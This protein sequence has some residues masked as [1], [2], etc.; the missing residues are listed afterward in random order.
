MKVIDKQES[1]PSVFGG[2]KGH[3]QCLI[4]SKLIRKGRVLMLLRFSWQVQ[5]SLARNNAC[6]E[7]ES[8]DHVKFHN[9]VQY[10][11]NYSWSNMEVSI[12]KL[13]QVK[14]MPAKWY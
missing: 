12:S 7:D 11:W 9:L 5:S 6:A 8:G 4:R 3:P 10:Y 14:G 2:T 1:K 13:S